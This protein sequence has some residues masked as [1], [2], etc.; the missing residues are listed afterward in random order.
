MK[1]KVLNEDAYG[2]RI[3]SGGKLLL[4]VSLNPSL[5]LRRRN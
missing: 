1:E 2:K 5:H 3:G 4:F